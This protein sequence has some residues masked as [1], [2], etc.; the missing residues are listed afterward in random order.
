M[1][2]LESKAVGAGIPERSGRPYGAAWA[3]GVS[4]RRRGEA[5]RAEAREAG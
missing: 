1:A 2:A 5:D 4:K 3:A